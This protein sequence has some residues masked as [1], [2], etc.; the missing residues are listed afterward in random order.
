[1]FESV[2]GAGEQ[3]SFL[4]LSAALLGN[5]MAASFVT[6]A[7]DLHLPLSAISQRDFLG[8]C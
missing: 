2:S 3:K 7:D 4:I 6:G 1:M 5:Y 8:M